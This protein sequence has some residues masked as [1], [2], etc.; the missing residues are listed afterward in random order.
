MRADARRAL[1]RL[2][3]A[4]RACESERLCEALWTEGGLLRGAFMHDAILM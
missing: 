4:D 3:A 2:D 1:A